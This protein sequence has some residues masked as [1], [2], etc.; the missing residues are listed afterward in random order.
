M[1]LLP[2]FDTIS[3]GKKPW[4]SNLQLDVQYGRT[5]QLYQN[6]PDWDLKSAGH[7][8]GA[9][10]NPDADAK[11]NDFQAIFLNIFC[12]YPG[13]YIFNSRAKAKI[14]NIIRTEINWPLSCSEPRHLKSRRSAAPA[15]GKPRARWTLWQGPVPL[16]HPQCNVSRGKG[17]QAALSWR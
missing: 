6:Q 10:S 11:T 14:R 15:P 3:D 17:L 9:Y 5:N 2:L 16:G 4:D 8:D 13:L 12:F 7:Q 1:T